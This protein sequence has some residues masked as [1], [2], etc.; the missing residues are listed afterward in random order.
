MAKGVS[1]LHKLNFYHRDLKPDNFVISKDN[2]I[3]LIDFGIARTM[4][5]DAQTRGRGTGAYIAPEVY[6]T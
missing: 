6:V 4:A 2:K 1:E 3:K 5:K